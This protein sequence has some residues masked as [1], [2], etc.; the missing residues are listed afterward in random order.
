[1]SLSMF[2][3]VSLSF[4]LSLWRG[5]WRFLGWFRG[6]SSYKLAPRCLRALV[7]RNVEKHTRNYEDSCLLWRDSEGREEAFGLPDFSAWYIRVIFGDSYYWT[8]EIMIQVT[9]LK[10]EKKCLLLK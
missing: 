9:R 3:S 5:L 6:V 4:N 10:S 8:L 1:V 2:L 7:R